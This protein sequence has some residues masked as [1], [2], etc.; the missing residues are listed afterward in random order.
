MTQKYCLVFLLLLFPLSMAIAQTGKVSGRVIDRETG[1]PLIGASVSVLGTT[2]GAATDVDG[3]YNILQI[4]PG[5]YDVKTSF[6]GYQDVTISGIRVA[7]GLTQDVDFSLPGEDIEVEPII[8]IAQR[9]LIEKSATNVKRVI[10]AEDFEDL[11]VRGTS[12]YI[13]LVPG[14]V[15]Q[16]GEFI[17]LLIRQG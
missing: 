3:R 14:V 10:R 6:V 11:P 17:A 5:T 7:A 1:E 15:Q 2:L 9:P 8:I 12:A 16:Y 4:T 13:S